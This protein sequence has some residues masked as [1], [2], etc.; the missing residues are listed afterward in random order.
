[1]FAR[2]LIDS[3]DFARQG[4]E[5]RGQVSLSELPKVAEWLASDAE[6][7]AFALVG[8]LENGEEVLELSFQGQCQLVC[9]RCLEPLSHAIN[10]SSIFWVVPE[11]Q[12]NEFSDDGDGRES[13]KADRQ[14]DVYGLL[15]DE[16]LLSL[17]LSPR[18]LETQCESLGTKAQET[19]GA[20]AVLAGLKK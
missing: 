11:S 14:L 13:I 3:I 15:E 19:H 16:L 7:V 10:V 18:H 2:P 5:L 1:M 12:F 17:P 9:Q 8:R 4:K 6:Q 20:F